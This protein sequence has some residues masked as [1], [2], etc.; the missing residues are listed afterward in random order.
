MCLFG[1]TLNAWCSMASAAVVGAT[2]VGAAAVG[3]TSG[4]LHGA[5]V[6]GVMGDGMYGAAVLSAAVVGTAVCAQQQLEQQQW[7]LPVRSVVRR[8]V[9]GSVA[10]CW[11]EGCPVARR[12]VRCM[13]NKAKRSERCE[14]LTEEDT[15]YHDIV[16]AGT[17]ANVTQCEN[18]IRRDSVRASRARWCGSE[19]MWWAVTNSACMVHHNW[20][21]EEVNETG[22]M[23]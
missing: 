8:T 7:M 20:V 1:E 12:T 14:T 5:A 19:T 21:D 18:E 16:A 3:V 4:V 6:V 10:V 11:T 9:R 13:R 15:M 2:V 17:R 23:R 22:E